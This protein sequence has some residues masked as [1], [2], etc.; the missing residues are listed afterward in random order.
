MRCPLEATMAHLV[1]RQPLMVSF[2]GIGFDF[3]LMRGLLRQEVDD[4]ASHPTMLGPDFVDWQE[5]TIALCDQFKLLAAQSYD[6]LA[7]IWRVDS[8]NKY[9]K[10][11]NSLDAICQANG[12]GKK[13]GDGAQAPR[14]WAAG[15]IAKVLNDCSNDVLLTKRLFELVLTNDG[16]IQRSNGPITILMPPGETF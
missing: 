12:L 8:E 5:R 2:N 3:S 7:E 15:K 10:G 6:I 9:V 14:D 16:T 4:P 1:E 11:L 13:T